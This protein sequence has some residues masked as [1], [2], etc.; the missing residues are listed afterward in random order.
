MTIIIGLSG[1]KRAGKNSV[2]FLSKILV[3]EDDIGKVRKVALGDTLKDMARSIGWDG[4]K[5]EKGRRLLQLLGTQVVRECI[6]DEY[7]VKAARERIMKLNIETGPL[8]TFVPDVRFPNE[9]SMIRSLGGEL[10]RIRRP[11]T[12][13]VPGSE[14]PDQL[15]ISETALD[16][17]KDW[18]AVLVSNNMAELFEAVKRELTRLGLV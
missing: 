17:Y 12:E 11:V 3:D 5:D 2:Y 16:S 6:D 7:W 18:D 4:K 10:W 1:K 9:I 13:P 14:T 8:V 15:H